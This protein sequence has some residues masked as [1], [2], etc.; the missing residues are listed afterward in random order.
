MGAT[1]QLIRRLVRKPVLCDL[2]RK[3][4]EAAEAQTWEAT[5]E[6]EGQVKNPDAFSINEMR[7]LHRRINSLIRYKTRLY[8]ISIG[9]QA[10]GLPYF[11]KRMADE[12]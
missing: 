8:R 1:K 2:A 7:T 4:C 9:A 5:V 3:R 11:G 10:F 6:I 12:A